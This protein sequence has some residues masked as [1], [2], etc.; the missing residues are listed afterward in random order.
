MGRCVANATAKIGARVERDPSISPVMAGCTRCNRKDLFAAEVWVYILV[1]ST[2][3]YGHRERRVTAQGAASRA[4]AVSC[5][6][7]RGRGSR[8]ASSGVGVPAAQTRTEP[9]RDSRRDEAA[10]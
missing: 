3:R 5:A 10:V 6:G 4:A 9:G 1:T 8:L 7:A 2:S